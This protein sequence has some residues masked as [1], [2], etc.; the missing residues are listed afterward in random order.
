MKKSNMMIRDLRV[1]L[2]VRVREAL[3]AELDHQGNLGNRGTLVLPVKLYVKHL[4][5]MV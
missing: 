1:E 3:Q 4:L 5:S 2:V